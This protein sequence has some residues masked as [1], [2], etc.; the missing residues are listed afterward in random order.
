MINRQKLL[1][2][3][4]VGFAC[5]ATTKAHPILI[6]T[7]KVEW[8]TDQICITLNIDNHCMEHELAPLKEKPAIGEMAKRLARSILVVMPD[9]ETIKPGEFTTELFENTVTAFYRV[10]KNVSALALIHDPAS[11]LAPLARQIQLRYTDKE[12]KRTS[13]VRITSA[14]NHAVIRRNAP[15]TTANY[16]PFNE[17]VLRITRGQAP[18]KQDITLILEFPYRLLETWPA[19]AHSR[20]NIITTSGFSKNR[21]KVSEWVKENIEM[22]LPDSTRAKIDIAQVDLLDP[23]DKVAGGEKELTLSVFLTRLRIVARY[24]LEKSPKWIDLTWR[25]FNS[26]ILGFLV[27]EQDEAEENPLGIITPTYA[28]IRLEDTSRIMSTRTDEAKAKQ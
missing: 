4:L 5:V 17:P 12:L 8:S 26:A 21:K 3:L 23:A 9:G 2:I 14:G 11:K 18:E 24:K 20:N 25:G 7:G 13:T 16:D 22:V 10:P 27:I 19:L 1:G 28:T 6:H 15:P